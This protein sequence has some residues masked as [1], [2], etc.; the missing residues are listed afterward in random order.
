LRDIENV[1]IRLYEK[2]KIK[3]DIQFGEKYNIKGNTISS[4]KKRNSIPYELISNIAYDEKISMDYIINGIE[5]KNLN[6]FNNLENERIIELIKLGLEYE[7]IQ[8]ENKTNEASHEKTIEIIFQKI[9]E[10]E[11]KINKD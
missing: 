2:I 1:L 9:E 8:N 11:K 5:Y 4:W 10:L 3:K 6:E 7:N